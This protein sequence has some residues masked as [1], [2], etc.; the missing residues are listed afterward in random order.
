MYRTNA[1]S[2]TDDT[3]RRLGFQEAELDYRRGVELAP[4]TLESL[5]TWD[6]SGHAQCEKD[7]MNSFYHHRRGAMPG[8]Y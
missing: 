1:V 7:R 6:V 3:V 5:V 4:K 2:E 8:G